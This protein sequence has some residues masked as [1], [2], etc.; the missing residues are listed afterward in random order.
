MKD[1]GGV[2]LD[3]NW[4]EAKYSDIIKYIKEEHLSHWKEELPE[5]KALVYKILKVHYS[6]NGEEL[7]EVHKLFGKLENSLQLILVMKQVSLYPSISEYQ[8]GNSDESFDLMKKN[9]EKMEKE[10]DDVAE[11][12]KELEKVTN[13]YKMP[14]PGCQTF[15]K[16]YRKLKELD[17]NIQENINIEKDIMYKRLK[18][19][20]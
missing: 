20:G 10:Y 1:F 8:R 3:K 7:T 19:R 16:T 18:V 9:M 5:I 12:L 6:D 15:D 14:E 4:N 2:G 13:N 17:V 11:T